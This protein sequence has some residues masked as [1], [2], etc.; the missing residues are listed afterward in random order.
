MD[1]YLCCLGLRLLLGPQPVLML[2]RL[3]LRSIR[4]FSLEENGR[5]SKTCNLN[6]FYFFLYRKSDYERQHGER[7]VSRNGHRKKDVS[8]NSSDIENI[9]CFDL[10]E[11]NIVGVEADS[12]FSEGCI[13]IQMLCF[14]VLIF[15]ST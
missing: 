5:V 12:R 9:L 4:I 7:T 3:L 2:Q 11:K 8:S 14:D 10:Q 13:R 6:R 15:F 1:I